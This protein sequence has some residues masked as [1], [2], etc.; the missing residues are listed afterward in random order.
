MTSNALRHQL[1]TSCGFPTCYLVPSHSNW[2]SRNWWS[3]FF[4]FMVMEKI[5]CLTNP[6][7]WLNWI[8]MDCCTDLNSF[9]S[10]VSHPL[11]TSMKKTQFWCH[12]FN[13]KEGSFQ[14]W[15]V[16]SLTTLNPNGATLLGWWPMGP[17]GT[18]CGQ[19]WLQSAPV[20][21]VRSKPHME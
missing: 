13:G 3:T 7:N 6:N 5:K 4:S 11:S 19:L 15:M 16:W 9:W 8:Q 14:A 12:N 21:M 18:F 1:A 10:L 20:C 2:A 17:D